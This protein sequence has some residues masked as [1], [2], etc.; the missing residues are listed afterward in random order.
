LNWRN[1][2][3]RQDRSFAQSLLEGAL[4]KHRNGVETTADWTQ[5]MKTEQARRLINP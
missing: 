4:P 2:A 1:E 3:T 5:T